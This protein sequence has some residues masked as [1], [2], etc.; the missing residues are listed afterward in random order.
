MSQPEAEFLGIFRDEANER[1][2]S[3]STVLLAIED[4]RASA[5]AIDSLFR[6]AHTIKG[7]AGMLGLDEISVLAH[8]VED[9]LAQARASGEL[10]VG[11]ADPLLR[12][13]DALHALVNGD[14][15]VDR[16]AI[17]ALI[18]ELA[19]EPAPVL[20]P[21]PAPEP[22]FPSDTADATAPVEA[23]A[24]PE[25]PPLRL[26]QERAAVAADGATQHAAE[27]RGVTSQ[28]AAARGHTVRVP[29]EKLDVLLDLVGET[30]LHRQRLGHMVASVDPD[31]RERLADELDIGDRLLGALQ[32]AAIQTRTL[33]FGSITGPYPRAIRDIANAEGKDVEFVV[34]GTETELDRVIL[35]GLSE[36]LVHILRNT[37]AHG[38]EL[39]AERLA[40][41]KSPRGRVLLTAEQRGGLVA[42]IVSDDGRGVSPELHARALHEGSLVDILTRP[43]FSTQTAVSDLAGRG[44]GL[45]VV[46]A[47]V[48]SFAGSMQIES[49]PGSGM[50]I[51][52][53][54]PLTLALLNVLLVERG[55]HVFGVPLSSVQEAVAVTETLSLTGRKALELRGTSIPLCDLAELLGAE[56]PPL[57]PR[58]P[59]IVVA[60]GGRRV[61]LACDR[62]VGESEVIVKAL[63]PLLAS[64]SGF[65]GAAILGDG[66]VALLLDPAS[67]TS[68]RVRARKSDAFTL[69]PVESRA[70]R[71]LLVVDDSFMVRELQRS[72]LEAAGYHVETAKHGLDALER[73][74]THSAIDLVVSDVDMPEMDGLSLTAAIRAS[75]EWQSLPVIL[76][77]SRASDDDRRRGVEVGADAYMVKDSFDQQALLDAVAQMV[78]T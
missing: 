66:R 76:V 59:A 23:A 44:V 11:L 34:E 55:S 58:S 67:A 71:T 33:P 51:T 20:T 35:E 12:A 50:S 78:G 8:A 75:A 18:A 36:P 63:G 52:L 5:D 17:S 37:I 49:E 56:A 27:R 25:G 53:L 43:G 29:A 21:G 57:P 70:S 7:A 16:E 46:K 41:G 62:L 24:E 9:V 19:S 39:P 32:D 2:E 40:A 60:G 77:T 3:M 30:V 1:L 22:S 38:I 13:G 4:G 72:I 61:A 26:V 48:E 31:Q 6:D 64:V 68:T 42:V 45:D 73:L 54:L 28:A 14:D 10:S 47:H 74:A 69:A 65:L 15:A